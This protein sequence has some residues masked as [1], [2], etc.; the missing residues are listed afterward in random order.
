MSI[1]R[2]GLLAAACVVLV[3]GCAG[4]N[5]KRPEPNQLALGKSRTADV[6][7]VMGSPQQTGEAVQ[8]EQKIKVLRYAYAEGA[9]EGR[10]PGVVPARAMV[11][12][13]HDDVLVGQEFVSSFKGDATEFDEGKLPSIVKGKTTRTEVVGLLGKPNGE[14]VYPMIKNKGEKAAVY[15]YSQAKGNVFNMKFHA[16]TLLVSFNGADVVSDVQYQSSGEK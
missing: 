7:A 10:Y 1:S 8:N 3:A 9:G 12:T 15:S 6:L 13:V 4:T 14:A 11:F 16:K 5:F 2:R